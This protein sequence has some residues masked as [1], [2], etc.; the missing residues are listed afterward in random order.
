MSAKVALTETPEENAMHALTLPLRAIRALVIIL[1]HI[2]YSLDLR[3]LHALE[4]AW[5]TVTSTPATALLLTGA[6][7]LALAAAVIAARR[8]H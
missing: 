1:W 3:L 4:S 2:A 6:P 5:T 7:L 8:S